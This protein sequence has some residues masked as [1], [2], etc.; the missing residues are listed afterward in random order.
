STGKGDIQLLKAEHIGDP[1]VHAFLSELDRRNPTL[2]PNDLKKQTEADL[3]RLARIRFTHAG[4]R[5]RG[6]Y[7]CLS[8]DQTPDWLICIIVP[9]SSILSSV[10]RGNR[11]TV[12]I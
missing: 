1:I 8:S 5:Y 10:H 2:K 7:R 4:V 12:F 3:Q 9:E 6:T 11:N